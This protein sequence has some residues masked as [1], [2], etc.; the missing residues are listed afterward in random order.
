MPKLEQT[1]HFHARIVEHGDQDSSSSE[2]YAAK[3]KFETVEW[4]TEPDGGS[5]LTFCDY[6]GYEVWGSWWII[7]KKGLN[8]TACDQLRQSLGWEGNFDQFNNDTFVGEIVQ[9]KVDVEVYEDKKQYKAV[10]MSP[11]GA[12][13]VGIRGASKEKRESVKSKY[14]SQVK[15]LMAAKKADGAVAPPPPKADEDVPF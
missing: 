13:I 9:I 14:G 3:F 1:G 5:E 8:E 7:G 2:A 12:P 6:P 4:Y 11:Q 10:W 15:A